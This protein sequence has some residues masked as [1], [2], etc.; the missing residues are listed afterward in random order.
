MG[1]RGRLRGWRVGRQL[2][3]ATAVTNA[4]GSGGVN[5]TGETK[6]RGSHCLPQLRHMR[7][8]REEGNGKSWVGGWVGEWAKGPGGWREVRRCRRRQ[9]LFVTDVTDRAWW[10]DMLNSISMKPLNSIAVDML[11]STCQRLLNSTCQTP[12]N[13]MTADM[14]NSS[15]SDM[16]N[17]SDIGM[18]NSMVAGML[19]SSG[20]DMLNSSALDML[21]SSGSDM[22]NSTCQ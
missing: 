6:E 14:L 9:P 19:N 1:G 12:L 16:F 5:S 3:F 21:N 13:S 2:L 11:N 7:A 10:L 15:G 20:S 17:S 8:L 4:P 22:L 18:F